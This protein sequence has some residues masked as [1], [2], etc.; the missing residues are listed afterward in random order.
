[1]IKKRES[2]RWL[3]CHL[4]FSNKKIK[5]P[6]L[7]RASI[8]SLINMYRDNIPFGFVSIIIISL[9]FYFVNYII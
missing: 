6:K 4:Y 2:K 5:A 1:M 8:L 7:L 9:F 3:D